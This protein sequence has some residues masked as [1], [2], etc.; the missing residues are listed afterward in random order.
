[1]CCQNHFW[2]KALRFILF[3]FFLMSYPKDSSA[4]ENQFRNWLGMEFVRIN[5]GT[6]AMGSPASEPLRSDGEHQHPVIISKPF[7]M[8]TTEVTLG[9]WRAVMG[10]GWFERRKG[11][12]EMPVTL[13][14]WHDCLRFIKKL[15]ERQEGFYRLPTEAEWEY[16]CR[17]GSKTAYSFGDAIDCSRGMFSNN[18]LKS[19]DCI[20]YVQSKGLPPDK[21]APVKSYLPNAWGLYDMHGNVWEWCYD[22]M[23]LYPK[24]A[25]RDPT[26][27]K[28]GTGRVRRGGSWFGEGDLCRSANRAYSHPATRLNTSGFRLVWSRTTEK[29]DI[30]I[31]PDDVMKKEQDGP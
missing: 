20:R 10:R 23:G 6:F 29:F 26:G 22:W 25:V 18:N 7:Y 4:F 1:M 5:E 13:V 21:S 24:E 28:S 30:P 9:Q 2:V 12:D 27:P 31:E 16:A 14:S 15:N 17:A 11:I 8:Q 3:S 19:G